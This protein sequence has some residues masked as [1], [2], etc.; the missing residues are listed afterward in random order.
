MKTIKINS[1]ST[2]KENIAKLPDYCYSILLTDNSL[3]KIVAGESGYYKM[4]QPSDIILD[5]QTL[6]E[7]VNELNNRI[8]VTMAEREA[9][10]TGSMFGWGCK[11]ANIDN[12]RF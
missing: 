11:G 3:I 10:E 4:N 7:F 5:G 1:N 8:G 9:M 6:D 2:A 12:Y